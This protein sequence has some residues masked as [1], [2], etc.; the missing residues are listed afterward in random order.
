MGKDRYTVNDESDK[1]HDSES[2][3][4]RLETH[5]GAIQEAGELYGDQAT[6]EQY[7]YVGRGNIQLCILNQ[8]SLITIS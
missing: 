8:H 1:A 4:T 6:A 3:H 2:L 7:G 5:E